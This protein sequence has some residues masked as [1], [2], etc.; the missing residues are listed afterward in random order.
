MIAARNGDER[1]LRVLLDHGAMVAVTLTLSRYD[2]GDAGE[3]G[4]C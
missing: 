1:I 3:R 4:G 2:I